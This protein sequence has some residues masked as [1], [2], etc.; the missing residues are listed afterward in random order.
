MRIFAESGTLNRIWS[1]KIYQNSRSTSHELKAGSPEYDATRW[2]VTAASFLILSELVIF[3]SASSHSF[4]ASIHVIMLISDEISSMLVSL[5]SQIYLWIRSLTSTRHSQWPPFWAYHQQLFVVFWICPVFR[6]FSPPTP[7]VSA[8][9]NSL[10]RSH[11]CF[12]YVYCITGTV[13][14]NL[15]WYIRSKSLWRWYINTNIMFLDIHRPVFICDFY[16]DSSLV[17]SLM[18][19]ESLIF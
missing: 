4:S 3:G 6:K 8:T 1:R 19:A 13:M 16:L 10:Y 14:S 12:P 15:S 18:R 5:L 11:F 9:L 17:Q 7:I 2:I